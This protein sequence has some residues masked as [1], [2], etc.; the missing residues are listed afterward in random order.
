MKTTNIYVKGMHCRS[1]ELRIE[2]ALAAIPG[3]QKVLVNHVTGKIS[4]IRRKNY[5][6]HSLK[7]LSPTAATLLV[8]KPNLDWRAIL[9]YG[10]T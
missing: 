5:R 6:S 7:K 10:K 4:S 2:D 8:K 9:Q 3:I 1:C